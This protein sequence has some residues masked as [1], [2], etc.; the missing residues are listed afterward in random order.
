MIACCGVHLRNPVASDLCGPWNPEDH[1]D[2]V[3]PDCLKWWRDMQPKIKE[4]TG[5]N[6]NAAKV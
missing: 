2:I 6:K 3:C 1:L 4:D 5:Q